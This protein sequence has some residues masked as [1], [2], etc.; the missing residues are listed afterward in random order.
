M[1]S[2]QPNYVI[3]VTGCCNCPFLDRNGSGGFTCQKSYEIKATYSPR[4][5]IP[6]N[7]PM[8]GKSITFKWIK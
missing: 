8:M 3:E 4:S 2:E 6:D 1:D 7:C 5:T